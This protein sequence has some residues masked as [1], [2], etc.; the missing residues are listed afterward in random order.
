VVVTAGGG[1]TDSAAKLVLDVA[2]GQT[3]LVDDKGV[4]QLQLTADTVAQQ[5]M[6]ETAVPEKPVSSIVE[7]EPT[8]KKSSHAGR[9]ALIGGLAVGAAV[10]AALGL[11]GSKS[12]SPTSTSIPAP[13]PTIPAH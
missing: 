6:A 3:L 1:P 10:G 2:G 7:N 11:R 4:S 13:I 12:Q 5:S 9:Y 8:A